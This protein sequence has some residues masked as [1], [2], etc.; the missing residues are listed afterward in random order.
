MPQT[1][2]TAGTTNPS[3]RSRIIKRTDSTVTLGPCKKCKKN[4]QEKP[5]K[6]HSGRYPVTCKKCG[7]RK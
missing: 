2:T 1:Q 6:A 7:G 5:L 4:W 3:A